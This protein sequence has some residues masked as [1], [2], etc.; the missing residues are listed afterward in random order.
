[1]VA[2]EFVNDYSFDW[3]DLVAMWLIVSTLA[4]LLAIQ[5]M[6]CALSL[7]V[8]C[9]GG[10]LFSDC[11]SGSGLPLGRYRPCWWWVVGLSHQSRR[12]CPAGTR[13]PT[14]RTNLFVSPMSSKTVG[15]DRHRSNR[16][17]NR[18]AGTVQ[19]I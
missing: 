17:R 11:K 6:E 3:S 15:I 16:T 4:T 5:V 14:T 18:T 13:C 7:W 19:A 1:M 2:I 12:D 9:H 10:V 8:Q